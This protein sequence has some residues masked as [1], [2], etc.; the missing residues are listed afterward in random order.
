MS[1]AKTVLTFEK[2][3]LA[4]GTKIVLRNVDFSI[5]HGEFWFFVGPN[6]EGKTTLLRSMLG[7]IRP[8]SGSLR[9]TPEIASKNV[10]FIPQGCNLNPTLRTTVR[11]FTSLGL[12]GIRL[13][14]K[15]YSERLAWALETVGLQ[16][17][18]RTDYWMLSGGQRQRALAAR[19]LVRRPSLLI[20]DEPTKGIDL[21]TEWRFLQFL[22]NLNNEQD[23]TIIFV[24]HNL[25]IA[26][27]YGSHAALFSGGS[28]LAG[29]S[30]LVLTAANLES[31]YGVPLTVGDCTSG[32][33]GTQIRGACG[34]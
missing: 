21:P 15:E 19:A 27:R 23:I 12:S 26:A 31:A 28:V 6:G 7:E 34:L 18:Q 11:E 22:S 33:T 29:K 10:G 14:G 16:G 9:Y 8:K 13:Y 17:M 25:D 32:H 20:L 5:N 30:E 24:A 2:V 4:Y 3:D 1:D